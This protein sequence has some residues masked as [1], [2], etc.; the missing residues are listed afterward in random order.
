MM[1]NFTPGPWRVEW[2]E[3]SINELPYILGDNDKA[4]ACQVGQYLSDQDGLYRGHYDAHLIAAAPDLLAA[5]EAAF[6]D[7]ALYGEEHGTECD[8]STCVEVIPQL[9]AAIAK[10]KGHQS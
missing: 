10:A 5:C 2:M 1:A 8:C 6:Y 4:V 7:L 9:Q 3:G